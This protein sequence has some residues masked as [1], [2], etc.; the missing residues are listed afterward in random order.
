MKPELSLISPKK[1]VVPAE[2]EREQGSGTKVR[3]DILRKSIETSGV[4]QAIIAIE[5]KGRLLVVKGTRRRQFAIELGQARVPV[6]VNQVPKGEDA[7][8]YR[9]R[10]RFVLDKC[11]QDLTP[12]QKAEVVTTLKEMF[13]MTHRQI[14]EYIGIA[15]DSVRNWLAVKNYIA[16]VAAAVDAGTLTMQAARVFDGLSET[17]QAEVWKAHA[18]DLVLGSGKSGKML[19]KDIRR[20]YSPEA[21]PEFYRDVKKTAE[22]LS[23]PATARKATKRPSYSPEEKKRLL[24]SFRIREDEL[25]TL[26]EESKRIN[27]EI[28]ASIAP[29]GAILRNEK[30]LAMVPPEMREELQAF[31]EK[32]C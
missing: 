2:Y 19:H 7:V 3:D 18:A 16:P 30:L 23:R 11:R 1:L 14:A 8:A 5:E 9:N 6:I 10:L 12:S 24:R 4:Q 26:K 20:T 13:G 15:P 27:A 28:A 17:G 29:I 25:A 31:G 22:R 21:R 32:Y